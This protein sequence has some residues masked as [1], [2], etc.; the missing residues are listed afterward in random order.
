M[1]N[2]IEDELK[3]DSIPSDDEKYI[4]VQTTKEHPMEAVFDI[5]PGSTISEYKERV[6][7]TIV[8]YSGY[9]AKDKEIEEQMQ[10]IYELSLEEFENV[11]E[12]IEGLEGKYK[13]RN[14]EVATEY[15][16][17]AL[18]ATRS[19][20]SL[21]QGK[22]KIDNA[23]KGGNTTNNTLVMSHTEVMQ[24][25]RDGAKLA[26]DNENPDDAIEGEVTELPEEQ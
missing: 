3:S 5:E 21:K 20:A 14:H 16:K 1:V 22:D 2:E 8:D 12:T 10:E 6:P 9:D 11:S 7:A 26:A 4:D 18:E 15:L 19:K 23:A 24:M 13:A 25:V 17:L